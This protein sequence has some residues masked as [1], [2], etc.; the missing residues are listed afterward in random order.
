MNMKM[1]YLKVQNE[2]TQI[3]AKTDKDTKQRLIFE[4]DRM[5]NFSTDITGIPEEE[6][7]YS[8]KYGLRSFKNWKKSK[9]MSL[10]YNKS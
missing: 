10:E 7:Q 8:N 3:A 2:G 6:R 4:V 1:K 5:R 9:L